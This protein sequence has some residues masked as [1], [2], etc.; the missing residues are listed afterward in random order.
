MIDAHVGD[1]PLTVEEATHR[2]KE[3]WARENDRKVIAWNAQLEQDCLEQ[4]DRDRLAREDEEAQRVQREKEAEE[5]RKEA[6]S[7]SAKYQKNLW[8]LIR[9]MELISGISTIS[10]ASCL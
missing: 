1:V 2:M 7:T 8:G 9:L 5:Q 3:A 4:E 10:S 6:E